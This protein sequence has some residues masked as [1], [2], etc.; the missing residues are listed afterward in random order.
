VKI[1]AQFEMKMEKIFTTF[2]Y[3]VICLVAK[4]CHKK[5]GKLLENLMIIILF[6]FVFFLYKPFSVYYDPFLAAAAATA[7]PNYRLQ[8]KYPFYDFYIIFCSFFY[9]FVL[10]ISMTLNSI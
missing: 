4:K 6:S 10:Y 5:I 8:V 3:R 2:F 7:D 1:E 9:D